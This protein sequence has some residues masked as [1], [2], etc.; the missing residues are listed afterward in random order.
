MYNVTAY[1]LYGCLAVLN[2]IKVAREVLT[3]KRFSYPNTGH[4]NFLELFKF[5]T[6]LV[7]GFAIMLLTFYFYTRNWAQCPLSFPKYQFRFC[8]CDLL[9]RDFHKFFDIS[10]YELNRFC[11]I[12]RDNPDILYVDSAVKFSHYMQTKDNDEGTGNRLLINYQY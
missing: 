4:L 1:I 12:H 9:E 8:E 11:V 7:P 2:I 3:S 5:L 6:C 10:E